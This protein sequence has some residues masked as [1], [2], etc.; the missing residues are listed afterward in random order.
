MAGP[1]TTNAATVHC[2]GA[3]ANIVGTRATTTSSGARGPT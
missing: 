2:Y 1:A 3:E